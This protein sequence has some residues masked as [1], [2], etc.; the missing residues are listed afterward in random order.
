MSVKRVAAAA[1]TP[2]V[3]A[4]PGVA[5]A[6]QVHDININNDVPAMYQRIDMPTLQDS[7]DQQGFQINNWGELAKEFQN[8]GDGIKSGQ[9]LKE[10]AQ[11]SADLDNA[12]QETD[13][14]EYRD[15]PDQNKGIE[16]YREKLAE[17]QDSAQFGENKGIEA[18]RERLAEK[19]ETEVETET[20]IETES[21]S[22]GSQDMGDG[23]AEGQ[24]SGSMDM[25]GDGGGGMDMGGGSSGMEM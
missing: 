15:P 20:E 2:L 13:Q 6:A 7:L 10:N 11:K 8:L 22:L 16:A 23:S 21:E 3:A 25:G 4:A 9:D 1:A 17:Q 24:D 5:S 18:Y 12:L 19:Q 14:G